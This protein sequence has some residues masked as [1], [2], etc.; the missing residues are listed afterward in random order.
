MLADLSRVGLAALDLFHIQRLCVLVLPGL[1]DH[2][3]SQVHCRDVR[4]CCCFRGRGSLYFLLLH[5]GDRA[6]K[7]ARLP[8]RAALTAQV[9]SAQWCLETDQQPRLRLALQLRIHTLTLLD[10]RTLDQGPLKSRVKQSLLLVQT[11]AAPQF[12]LVFAPWQPWPCH[13]PSLQ[14][15]WPQLQ[16]F[17]LA[18]WQASHRPHLQ[19]CRSQQQRSLRLVGRRVLIC[20]LGRLSLDRCNVRATCKQLFSLDDHTCEQSSP[21]KSCWPAS[22]SAFRSVNDRQDGILGRHRYASGCHRKVAPPLP[23]VRLYLG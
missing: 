8:Q 16:A 17:H 3:H 19:T 12:C 13:L 5:G 20:F 6:L 22:A 15:A 23:Q 18:G 4:W 2:A 9:A 14:R 11:S 1:V 21:R 10:P 7:E